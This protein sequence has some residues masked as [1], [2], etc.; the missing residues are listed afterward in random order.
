MG[1]RLRRGLWLLRDLGIRYALVLGAYCRS[2][3]F[4]EPPVWVVFPIVLLEV[5]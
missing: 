5:G 3:D 2:E 1:F 4:V